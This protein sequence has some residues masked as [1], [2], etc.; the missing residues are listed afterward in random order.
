VSPTPVPLS[1]QQT[2]WLTHNLGAIKPKLV[3]TVPLDPTMGYPEVKALV[4]EA[5]RSV[6]A[7]RLRITS[8]ERG[9]LRSPDA[10]SS[11]TIGDHRKYSSPG[12]ARAD[13]VKLS[14]SLTFDGSAGALDGSAGA[15]G[16]SAGTLCSVLLY[17]ILGQAGGQAQR[18]LAWFFDHL[19]SDAV[20]LELFEHACAQRPTAFGEIGGYEEW[21]R[22]QAG[23][24]RVMNSPEAEF[25]SEYLRGAQLR[26]CDHLPARIAG[27]AGAGQAGVGSALTLTGRPLK[28]D[29]A[30][31]LGFCGEL[32][33]T[34]FIIITATVALAVAEATAADD[35]VFVMS[36]HGRDEASAQ[37]FGYLSNLVPLRLTVKNGSGPLLALDRVRSAVIDTSAYCSTPWPFINRALGMP[38]PD[39]LGDATVTLNYNAQV[40]LTVEEF[41]AIDG[42]ASPGQESGLW[43]DIMPRHGG[44]GFYIVVKHD[45]ARYDRQR[46]G[47]LCDSIVSH[48]EHIMASVITRA[49]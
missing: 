21:L 9:V 34:P 4:R 28:A 35:M 7:L 6:E 41:A 12:E 15:L 37:V 23:N 29:N 36:S 42:L 19:I 3:A 30:P 38:R 10:P 40:P 2:D 44:G 39:A 43:I 26:T 33:V 17:D 5:E 27:Q 45:P 1:W 31:F 32:R 22:R 18:W 16:G 48:W 8:A 20:S 24:F 47:E 25:W 14:Y 49:G 11:I 13:L 46:V